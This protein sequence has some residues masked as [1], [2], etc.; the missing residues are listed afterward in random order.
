MLR[1]PARN[2]WTPHRGN[3]APLAARFAS[4]RLSPA[5]GQRPPPYASVAPSSPRRDTTGREVS[6]PAAPFRI[7]RNRSGIL[8]CFPFPADREYASADSNPANVRFSPD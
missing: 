8:P 6:G 4:A 3:L 2:G 7:G 5:P 1:E